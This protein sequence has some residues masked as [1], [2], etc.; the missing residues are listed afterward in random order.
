MPKTAWQIEK[1]MRDNAVP[2]DRRLEASQWTKE[3]MEFPHGDGLV[4]WHWNSTVP[5]SYAPDAFILGMVQDWA[6]Q[7]YDVSA[8]EALLPKGL[9]LEAA[10]N[11]PDLK[12]VTARV[13]KALREAPKIEGHPY[14]SY[15]HPVGW[16]AVKA[17]MPAS[18]APQAFPGWREDFAE[19]IL[20]GWLG[21]MAGGSYGTAI[22]GYTGAQ[23]T[24][25]YGEISGY[26]TAPET[27][28][29]DVVYELVLLDVFEKFGRGFSSDALADEWVRQLP[30]GV[31]AEGVALRNLGLG[32]YP[33]ESGSYL[34]PYCDWIGAQMRGM[35]CG[36]LAPA[37]PFEAA[38]LAHVD[39]VV[40]HAR[41]GIYGEIYS[42]V[43]P[44]LAFVIADPR[45]LLME[46]ARYIPAHSEYAAKLDF[47]FG[48]LKNESDPAAAWATLEPHFEQY[49]WIHAYPNLAADVFALWY[50]GGDFTTSMSLLAKAGL[51]VDCNGGLVGNVLGI[52][53]PVPPAWSDPIGDLL[54]TYIPGKERLSI[55]SL[56][57]QTARLARS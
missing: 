6:N 33:P 11:L 18:Q 38:R 7:G 19:R 44:A 37:N 41:N 43:L 32:I 22:E 56:A 1:D 39:A 15:Q 23:I 26:V 49:N 13:M 27:T 50:G 54:E 10:G 51:D 16:Q 46:A 45:E 20:Q 47:C 28:N 34:N 35:V 2:V 42:A 55:R 8:A 48:V 53:N 52:L 36:M 30:F 25:V 3:E 31:S 5:G 4:R 24:R 21:Q 29:D 12:V 57:Q 9:A 17:A 40:S 14:H